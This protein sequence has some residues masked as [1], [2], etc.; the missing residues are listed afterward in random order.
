MEDFG[1]F[2]RTNEVAELSMDDGDT[3]GIDIRLEGEVTQLRGGCQGGWISEGH[4]IS[5][6]Q[7]AGSGERWRRTEPLWGKTSVT[8]WRASQDDGP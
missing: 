1:S 8:T 7:Q 3:S 4:H 6:R 5:L 2:Q